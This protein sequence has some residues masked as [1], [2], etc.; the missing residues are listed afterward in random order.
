MNEVNVYSHAKHHYVTRV[1]NINWELAG[2]DLE[3]FALEQI[4]LAVEEPDLV[5]LNQDS[6]YDD[7]VHIRNGCAVPV[8]E[9]GEKKEVPTA[10]PVDKY[11]DD[12]NEHLQ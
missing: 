2:K 9:N 5:L 7:P 10:F 8:R 3:K 4:E 6:D 11:E 12:I 1:M